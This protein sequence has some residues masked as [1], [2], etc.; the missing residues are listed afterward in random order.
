[1]NFQQ[2]F[3]I[4]FN[5]TIDR[6]KA[7]NAE[8]ILSYH[9]ELNDEKI[10]EYSF[11]VESKMQELGEKK[12]YVKRIFSI[13]IEALQNMHIHGEKAPDG[14]Q[15]SYM[16]VARG[17]EAYYITF[18]NLIY[19]ENIPKIRQR[20][21]YINSLTKDQLKEYYMKVLS[22]GEISQKGG[23][24][25]GF[26]TIGMKSKNKMDYQFFPI[27]HGLSLFALDSFANLKESE[28]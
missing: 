28:G 14:K 13:L 23:A 17:S 2:Q 18:A 7:K 10:N 8:I 19:D 6:F 3:D 11:S 22:D 25:L 1:M 12:G 9:G 4:H 26:I 15:Y 16:V 24:G 21:E 20:V 5:Q 27:N